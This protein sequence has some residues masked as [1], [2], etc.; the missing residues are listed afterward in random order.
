MAPHATDMVD[1]RESFDAAQALAK[2]GIDINGSIHTD[3]DTAV[4]VHHTLSF[5]ASLIMC[6]YRY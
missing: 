3:S 4:S 2:Y 1:G 5:K 6:R